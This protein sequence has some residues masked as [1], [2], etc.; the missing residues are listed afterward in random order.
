MIDEIELED[1]AGFENSASK[2]QV[3]F[4]RGRVAGGMIVHQDE[5]V[6]GVDNCWF[7]DF[8]RTG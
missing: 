7:K 4:G 8:A 3:G 5:G 1:S 2:P 6:G